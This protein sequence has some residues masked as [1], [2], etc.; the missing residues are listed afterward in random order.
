MRKRLAAIVLLMLAVW[1]LP[2]MAQANEKVEYIDFKTNGKSEPYKEYVLE[3]GKLVRDD[4]S[5]TE[6]TPVNSNTVEWSTGNYVVSS[7]VTITGRITVSGFVNLIL[8]DGAK[9]KANQGI[10]AHNG[11]YLTIYAQSEDDNEMGCIEIPSNLGMNAGIGGIFDNFSSDKGNCG[12]VTFNGGRISF[13]QGESGSVNERKAAGI[14]GAYNG[15]GGKITV[16]G[17]IIEGIKRYE[18][19]CIGGGWNGTGNIFTIN[20]GVIRNL[21]SEY[22]AAIGGGKRHNNGG[23]GGTITINGGTLTS[24]SSADGACIGGGSGGKGGNITINGGVI[25]LATNSQIADIDGA[26]IGGGDGGAGGTITINGGTINMIQNQNKRYFG[27]GIGGGNGGNGGTIKITGGNITSKR[28]TGI[29]AIGSGKNAAAV[30]VQIAPA[31]G[32]M[33]L[34]KYG[35]SEIGRYYENEV[36]HQ[37]DKNELTIKTEDNGFSPVSIDTAPQTK[38]MLSDFSFT[39][40]SKDP[41]GL[42]GFTVKYKTGEQEYSGTLPTDLGTYDVLVSRKQTISRNADNSVNLENSY[43]RFECEIPGGLTIVKADRSAPEQGKDFTVGDE[44]Y[45]GFG[46]GWLKPAGTDALEYRPKD[47][48]DFAALDSCAEGLAPGAYVVR[49]AETGTYNASEVATVN[50]LASTQKTDVQLVKEAIEALPDS[51]EPDDVK[52][53]TAIC[54][55]QKLFLALGEQERGKI[56]PRLVEKLNALIAAA[57]RYV[58]VEGDGASVMAAS[59]T[60]LRFVANGPAQWLQAVKVDGSALAQSR[61]TVE[62]G[63]TIVTLHD[64]YVASLPAGEHTLTLVYNDGSVSAQFSVL[65]ELNLPQ[66]GDNSGFAQWAALALLCAG[67]VIALLTRRKRA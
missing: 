27:A 57:F 60:A 53:V 10:T 46:D 41:A 66:T 59:K 44:T 23:Y 17:G 37:W 15:S 54:D 36:V 34:V 48:A 38:T 29:A 22:G 11:N 6:Y 2:V 56:E 9:L 39:V 16:N 61:Y 26:G 45:M 25:T 3:S 8:K 52:T 24:I 58:I 62:S 47:A 49:F 65:A 14:G 40:T 51:V 21:S 4:K 5:V 67:G 20:G 13:T 55:A 28:S 18:G 30:D 42:D 50:I 19:A 63:S 1:A 31:E 33:I 32:N 35:D 64:D 7:E 12:T 43:K